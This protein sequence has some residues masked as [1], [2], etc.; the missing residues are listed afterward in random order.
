MDI[1]VSIFAISVSL[2]LSISINS[3]FISVFCFQIQSSK[4]QLILMWLCNNRCDKIYIL[5]PLESF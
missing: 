1:T 3:T 2:K 4:K 5:I